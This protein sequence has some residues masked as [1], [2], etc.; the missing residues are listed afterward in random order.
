MSSALREDLVE[1][2]GPWSR[3][4]LESLAYFADVPVLS[5]D[6]G[7]VESDIDMALATI[8]EKTG[9]GGIVVV[10]HTPSEE[11]VDPE[12]PGPQ[13]KIVLPVSVME[14]PLLNRDTAGGGTGKPWP[15]VGR[16]VKGGLHLF[17]FGSG[18]VLTFASMQYELVKGSPQPTYFFD[19]VTG[20]TPEWKVPVPT[21]RQTPDGILLSCL[22]DGAAIWYTLDGSYPRPGND[23]ALLYD[24]ILRDSEGEPVTDSVG[25]IVIAPPALP[26]EADTLLL[27]AAYADG[28]LGSNIIRKRLYTP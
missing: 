13:S 2:L 15:R 25:D 27:V 14:D 18:A 26:L 23:A 10:V 7:V 17:D 16:R 4:R 22:H 20:E 21:I 8:N 19:C 1:W 24:D 12:T 28:Y 9:K 5:E 11:A 6:A 3:E